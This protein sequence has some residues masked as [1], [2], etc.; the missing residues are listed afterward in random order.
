VSY[1]PSGDEGPTGYIKIKKPKNKLGET[2]TNNKKT[3]EQNLEI[4]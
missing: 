1:A 2:K 4:K 3:N